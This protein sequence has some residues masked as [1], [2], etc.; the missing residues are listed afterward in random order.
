MQEA[1][2]CKQT[3]PTLPYALVADTNTCASRSSPCVLIQLTALAAQAS[4][5]L[6]VPTVLGAAAT[7]SVT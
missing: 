3:P 1:Q 2:H 4:P 6:T 5:A 7:L